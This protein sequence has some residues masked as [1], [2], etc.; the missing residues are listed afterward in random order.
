MLTLFENRRHPDEGTV[1]ASQAR[2]I[3]ARARLIENQLVTYYRRSAFR[4]P[5][6]HL[7]VQ[8]LR[9]MQYSLET[10][11]E[12]VVSSVYARALNVGR[13]FNFTSAASY[14]GPHKNQFFSSEHNDV[15][16]FIIQETIHEVQPFSEDRSWVDIPPVQVLH[17]PVTDFHFLPPNGQMR[18]KAKGYGVVVVDI[19]LMALQFREFCLQQ[20]QAGWDGVDPN[21]FVVQ[22]VIPQMYKS[23]MDILMVNQALLQQGILEPSNPLM[24][25]PV[26]LPDNE[27]PSVIAVNETLKFAKQPGRQYSNVLRNLPTYFS[28]DGL[29]ALRMPSMVPTVQSTWI[30]V[31]ARLPHIQF[32]AEIAGDRGRSFNSFLIKDFKREIPY[33]LN[34]GLG[35]HIQDPDLETYFRETLTAFMDY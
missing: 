14:G 17:H 21:A 28:K 3:R 9:H 10:P 6:N 24:Y 7:L 22:K 1:T 23:Y 2:P 4:L 16:D 34:S 32:L 18:N 15:K 26:A 11:F 30:T 27:R 12:K 35:R 19:A 33:Y 25:L 8:V 5:N 13:H 31:L 20:L 29:S